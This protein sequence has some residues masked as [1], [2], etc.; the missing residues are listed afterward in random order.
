MAKTSD[1]SFLTADHHLR[2]C[3]DPVMEVYDDR[4]EVGI[5]NN[6]SGQDTS[7]AGIP[8]NCLKVLMQVAAPA[9]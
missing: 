9:Y 5:T 7:L 1:Y 8:P 4:S 3:L 6:C 2:K